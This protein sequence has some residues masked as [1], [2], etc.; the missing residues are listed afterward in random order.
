MLLLLAALT[1]GAAAQR[2]PDAPKVTP[3]EP[4]GADIERWTQAYDD[5]GAPE[6]LVMCGWSSGNPTASA[7]ESSFF[8]LRETPFAVQLQ[9]AFLDVINDPAADVYLVDNGVVRDTIARLQT[10]L[11][12]NSERSAMRLLA[13]EVRADMIVQ[14]QL[15]DRSSNDTP[16]RVRFQSIDTTN[17]RT[18]TTKVFDWKLGNSTADVKRYADQIAR[19][20]INDIAARTRNAQRYN[21]RVFGPMR[22]ATLARS[23]KNWIEGIRG[24]ER[25]R[26]RTNS[27]ERHPYTGTTEALVRYD[28]RYTGD[29]MDL[30]AE[31]AVAFQ[32][33]DKVEVTVLEAAGRQL[34]LNVTPIVERKPKDEGPETHRKCL[35][36]LLDPGEAGQDFRDQI[37]NHYQK[38]DSPSIA[39]LVNRE[40]TEDEREEL[41][42]EREPG[43]STHA[44]TIVMI[45]QAGGNIGG[46]SQ[47][48]NTQASD[49]DERIRRITQL[50]RQTNLVEA[51]LFKLLGPEYMDFERKD[52]STA[53]ASL[54]KYMDKQSSV[55]GLHELVEVLHQHSIVDIVIFGSG[56]D[57]PDG[58]GDGRSVTYTFRAIQISDAGVV[59]VASATQPLGRGRSEHEIA[60]TIAES[61]IKDLVCEMSKAWE[62][63]NELDVTLT[64]VSNSDDLDEFLQAVTN[65]EPDSDGERVLKIVGRTG[66]EGDEGQGTASVTINYKCSFND[67]FKW[68][69]EL[70]AQLPYDLDIQ[71]MDASQAELAL[72]R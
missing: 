56:A 27:T 20:F 69:R 71:S 6:I 30:S 61:A 12:N 54:L 24:V 67:L 10:T 45:N 7:G 40:P 55:Y 31:V 48:R 36:M 25:V 59:G 66:F 47:R 50:E 53:R 57:L 35:E 3:P 49:Q 16:N 22:D 19:V 64:N 41:S 17:G 32:D 2:K 60:K 70:A 23:I 9:G 58:T 1:S 63:P 33:I 38:Q 34:T 51:E 68:I 15:I 26:A 46:S 8:N 42:S 44:D 21:L 52:A 43:S 62:P 13:N 29:F 11:N 4:E 18:L 14:I 39:V 37:S 28:V 5:F 65:L 72:V